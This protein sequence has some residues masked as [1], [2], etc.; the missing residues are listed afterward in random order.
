[1]TA[2][3]L[4]SRYR[5]Y[6]RDI[7]EH[8]RTLGFAGVAICWLFKT[9]ALVFPSLIYWALLFFIGYFVADFLLPLA[10]AVTL[11]LFTE[12]QEKRL[13]AEKRNLDGEIQKPRW[14]DLPVFYFFTAKCVLLLAG[15]VP[16]GCE[17]MGRIKA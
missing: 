17:L 14:V 6:T 15:F 3:T 16:V 5:E 2:E 11:K 4:W 7:T 8:A 9:D 10:G 12:A 13:W 1:V